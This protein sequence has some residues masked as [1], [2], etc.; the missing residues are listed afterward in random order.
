M[1]ISVAAR[2]DIAALTSL[3]NSAYRG[4]SS[5]QGWTTEADL[6]K[7]SQRTDEPSM[8]VLLQDTNA[9]ILKYVSHDETITG[10]VYLR[11]E[12]GG[13]YLGMLTVSPAAQGQGIGK[14]LLFAAENYAANEGC[15]FIIMNVISVR[16]ELIDWYKKHGYIDTGNRSPF[17]EDHRFGVPTRELEF[18]ILKKEILK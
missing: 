7:G 5:K 14:K 3:I 6:L 8:A 13:L 11:H 15:T 1:P 17:P 18:M 4:E 16:H 9:R 10:C 12:D 2:E